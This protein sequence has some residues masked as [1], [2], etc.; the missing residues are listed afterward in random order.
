M[1]KKLCDDKEECPIC[2]EELNSNDSKVLVCKHSF[3]KLC[4]DTWLERK[5]ICP[6]CRFHLTNTYKCR[7][8]KKTF[9]TYLTY[10]I[11]LNDDHVLFKN[12]FSTH[13]Y[14]YKKIKS[15]SYNDIFFSINYYENDSFIIK[16]FKFK[17]KYI[18]ENFFKSITNKFELIV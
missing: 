16:S 18:C 5:N 3:H 12:W 6:L 1:D 11:T 9:L 13:K 7:D 2:L 8:I 10:K 15:I 17:N 14:Y 4:I